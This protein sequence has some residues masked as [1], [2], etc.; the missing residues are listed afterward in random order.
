MIGPK[1]SL[2][3]T[4]VGLRYLQQMLTGVSPEEWPGESLRSC[5]FNSADWWFHPLLRKCVLI[6]FNDSRFI[7]RLDSKGQII[8]NQPDICPPF[9]VRSR[10]RSSCSGSVR[11]QYVSGAERA[12]RPGSPVA[13]RSP[14]SRPASSG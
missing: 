13:L 7:W 5:V 3:D 11:Y 14:W 10:H 9:Q 1:M 12:R 8:C 2:T 4:E 6:R